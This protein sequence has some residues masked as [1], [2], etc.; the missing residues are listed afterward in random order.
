MSKYYKNNRR[1]LTYTS[2]KESDAIMTLFR[3]F[4]LKIC[5]ICF[6]VSRENARKR[7][8]LVL[9]VTNELLGVF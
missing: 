6:E 7:I 4:M 1:N 8:Y 3:L 5:E 2:Y 9:N